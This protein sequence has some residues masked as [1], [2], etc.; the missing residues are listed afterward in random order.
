MMLL[1]GQGFQGE[2]KWVG[3]LKCAARGRS[4]SDHTNGLQGLAEHQASRGIFAVACIRL[5]SLDP[6]YPQHL[7]VMI[8]PTSAPG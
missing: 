2:G 4:I 8:H 6:R 3:A 1:S 7:R 5:S